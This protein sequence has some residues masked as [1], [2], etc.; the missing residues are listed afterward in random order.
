MSRSVSDSIDISFYRY[1]YIN[2]LVCISSI[3]L[4]AFVG[5]FLVI[6]GC[7][8]PKHHPDKNKMKDLSFLRETGLVEEKSPAETKAGVGLWSRCSS[9]L[10]F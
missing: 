8:H 2:N 6:P 9:Q 4:R 10:G 1:I 5:F 7:G 3:T